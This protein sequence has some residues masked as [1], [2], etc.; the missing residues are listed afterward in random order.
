MSFE[1]NIK[2]LLDNSEIK[3]SIDISNYYIPKL[4]YDKN[5]ISRSK[6]FTRKLLEMI[7][8][9]GNKNIFYV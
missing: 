8:N 1:D 5:F 4:L 6:I 2:Q 7:T 9:S 3:S